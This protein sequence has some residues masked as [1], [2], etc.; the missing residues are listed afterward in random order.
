MSII[1]NRNKIVNTEQFFF[2]IVSK[3]D[4]ICMDSVEH[5]FQKTISL[6]STKLTYYEIIAYYIEK[7]DR[8]KKGFITY[9]EYKKGMK[10]MNSMNKEYILSIFQGYSLPYQ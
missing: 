1:Q 3:N 2:D 10:D 6:D 5:I 9:S 7:W 8:D 4:V